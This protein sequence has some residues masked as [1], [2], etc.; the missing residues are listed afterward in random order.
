MSVKKRFLEHLES[1]GCI[2]KGYAMGGA[3]RHE[4]DK[5]QDGKWNDHSDTSGEPE[6]YGDNYMNYAF[7]GQIE[8]PEERQAMQGL[9]GRQYGKPNY[10]GP[11]EHSQ[12]DDMMS[13]D[14]IRRR[15]AMSV[16]RRKQ[17]RG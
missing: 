8:V 13:D 12:P 1:K 2:P 10:P 11:E 14:E 5:W 15:L 4:K 7:G 6:T 9:H 3:V 16:S 17:L